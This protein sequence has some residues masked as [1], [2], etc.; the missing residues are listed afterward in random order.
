MGIALDRTKAEEE[1]Q[2]AALY[3][4]IF[5]R[6]CWSLMLSI[7]YRCNPAF[8]ELTGYSF[9]EIRGKEPL[10][11]TPIATMMR[12]ADQLKSIT[13]QGYWQVRFGTLV[14]T[15][16]FFNLAHHQCHLQCSR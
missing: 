2:L 14:K 12:F 16:S 11:C 6:Q 5:Q 15:V 8:S 1:L 10:F 7:K 4:T 9:E 13:Q 3:T